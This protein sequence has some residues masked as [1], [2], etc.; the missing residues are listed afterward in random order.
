MCGIVTYLGPND[1]VRRV[2]DA[3]T[4]LTYRAPDAS[5]IAVLNDSDDDVD[6]RFAIRRVVGDSQQLQAE[7]VHNPLPPNHGPIV[8][9]HG[10]WAM[11]GANSISNT[12]PLT[13]R[14][15]SRL[16]VENGS[17]N[18]SLMLNARAEQTAWWHQRG[19]PPHEPIHRSTNTTEVIAFE[20]E[21]LAHQLAEGQSP[22]SSDSFLV[23]LDKNAI[24]DHEERALRLALWRLREGNGHACALYSTQ[25]PFTLYVSSHHKSIT[26][27]IRSDTGEIMVASDVNAALMLW[28]EAERKMAKQRNRPLTATVIYL[29]HTLCGGTELLA[30]IQ[31]A[32][33]HPYTPAQISLSR[34]DGQP[35][36]APAQGLSLSL[37]MV[38]KQ[39]HPS[40]TEQHIAE[41]PDVLQR[42]ANQY[43]PQGNPHLASVW[44]A[45][46]LLKP[47]LNVGQLT[48]RFGPR[49]AQLHRLLLVGE[50]SSWRDA[51]CAA[52]LLRR[53]LPGVEVVVARP[54]AMLNIGPDVDPQ[55]DLA[56]LI[57]WS[58]TT[59]ALLK[60]EG[61][62]AD[63]GLLRLSLTGRPQSDLG[64][65]TASSGG[66]IDVHTGL[67]TAV[68]TT[69]GFVAILYTLNLLALQLASVPGKP[70]PEWRSFCRDLQAIPA[71][72]RQLLANGNGRERIRDTA[73]RCGRFNKVAVVGLS[74]V[75]VE[76]ELK[77]EELAQIVAIAL[78]PQSGSLPALIERTAQATRDE[79]R[80]LFVVNASTPEAET[81]VLPLLR[82]LQERDVLTLVLHSAT[83]NQFSVFGK[84]DSVHCFTVPPVTVE[85]QPLL[86]ALFFFELAVGLA[87]ARGLS[88]GEIDRPRNLAKS[89][90]TTGAERYRDID[91]R[92]PFP[93]PGL[94][95]FDPATLP[96]LLADLTAEQQLTTRII[97]DLRPFWQQGYDKWQIIGGGQDYAAAHM[98]ARS[99]RLR[100]VMAEAQYTD[101]AWH[102][103][104]AAVG[105]P[106][107]AHDALVLVLALDPLFQAAALVD[108]QVYRVRNA[109]VFL[110][111]PQGH[112]TDE[113]VQGVEALGVWGVT[114]VSRP[115]TYLVGAALGNLLAQL[116]SGQCVVRS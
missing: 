16:V 105:G 27:A 31:L 83:S 97:A 108:T 88:S 77:I 4:L 57:S 66:T 48:A 64:R 58:G 75:D 7:L 38:A 54:V 25:R 6:G 87:C 1:G 51:L 52:P 116:Q 111:V 55:R 43:L 33:E 10:R 78:P 59:D 47:G 110:V 112:E 102:G 49:L 44:Q 74:P 60:V 21:R 45:D 103:P 109:P 32:P 53:L 89:V 106:D 85:C 50:G 84:Q 114:A 37:E 95:E 22:A 36:T 14:S 39:G 80:T 67:E 92:S 91:G 13:D 19:L 35:I 29:D 72:A 2:L 17:H 100:G 8:V 34:Y 30:T 69:K 76:G 71:L 9:G 90:T 73:S 41:I 79:E 46:R 96:P 86:D 56:I 28:S 11:V 26:L 81:A 98:I 18:A 82:K 3:L 5:G 94:A 12:H 42:L 62:L 23:R 15:R 24:T 61:W 101:S 104:L 107:A 113:A 40:Y 115:F 65:R 99:L 93:L 70:D 68:A 20:W 63:A